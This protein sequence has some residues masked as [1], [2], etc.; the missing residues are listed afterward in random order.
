MLY[1]NYIKLNKTVN[2]VLSLREK[3][4]VQKIHSYSSTRS[5]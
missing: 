5:K 4:N 3:N 2:V 1:A